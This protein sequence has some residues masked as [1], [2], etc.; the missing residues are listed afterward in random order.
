MKKYLFITLFLLFSITFAIGQTYSGNSAVDYWCLLRINK[1]STV[2]F[3]YSLN[4]NEFY[5]E[6]K[7]TI[8]KISDSTY[9]VSVKLVYGK[10]A[11]MGQSTYDDVVKKT[12]DSSYFRVDTPYV[13][14]KDTVIIK[15]ANGQTQNYIPYNKQ[16]KHSSFAL[17]NSLK[18]SRVQIIIK[19]L[20]KGKIQLPG[21]S[22]HLRSLFIPLLFLNQESG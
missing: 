10:S 6:N 14:L 1:D 4:Y 11:T 3:V 16:G 21:S 13:H 2:N 22:Y 5:G 19:L 18:I 7:G 17:D 12:Y 20:L 8:K 15:Y 9:H